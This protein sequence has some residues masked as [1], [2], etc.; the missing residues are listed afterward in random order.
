MFLQ[1]Q[2][3]VEQTQ[4]LA[5]WLY[6]LVE[7]FSLIAKSLSVFMNLSPIQVDFFLL[8]AKFDEIFQEDIPFQSNAGSLEEREEDRALWNWLLLWLVFELTNEN[9]MDCQASDDS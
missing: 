8:L 5:L 1:Y 9:V 7:V 2:D 4:V 6:E 3:E